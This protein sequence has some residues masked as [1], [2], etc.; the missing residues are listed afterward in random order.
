MFFTCEFCYKRL[1][2]KRALDKHFCEAQKRRRLLGSKMGR[3]AFYYYSSWR[4]KKGFSV[5]DEETFLNSKFFKS[6]INFLDFSNEKGIPDRDGYIDLMVERDIAPM[7][8]CNNYYYEYYMEVFDDVY[9]PIRQYE[10]TLDF[11]GKV[12]EAT[13]CDF[14]EILFQIHPI[15]LMKLIAK[16]KVSPWFLLFTK[17]FKDYCREMDKEQKILMST[18][19]PI[20]TWQE[21]IS[22]KKEEVEK[23]KEMIEKLKV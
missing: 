8:W 15:D 23:I 7:H 17:T 9:D 19:I 13:G 14:N 20:M 11:L 4:K 22:R 2:S 5:V 21:R 3:T 1:Q 18:I 10:M 6:F 12:R 16:R